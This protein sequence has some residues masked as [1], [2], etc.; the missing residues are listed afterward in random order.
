MRVDL[1]LDDLRGREHVP[2]KLM[3]V[4]IPAEVSQKIQ[5][6]AEAL[7]ASK[8]E[9]VIALLNEGLDVSAGMLKNARGK[10]AGRGRSARKAKTR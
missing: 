9:V 10:R 5:K 8:T 2:S 3:N 7:K 1:R 6:V 4:K